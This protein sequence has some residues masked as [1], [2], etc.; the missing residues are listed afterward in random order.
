[1]FGIARSVLGGSKAAKWFVCCVFSAN[2]CYVLFCPTWTSSV[3][4]GALRVS[5]VIK[6]AHQKSE[7]RLP[8]KGR[9]VGGEEDAVDPALADTE[10]LGPN[11]ATVPPNVHYR[12]LFP[13]PSRT[14]NWTM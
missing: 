8:G 2:I 11:F 9:K 4:V 1:M 14:G 7:N 5:V 10:M 6:E 3:I 12:S 13:L